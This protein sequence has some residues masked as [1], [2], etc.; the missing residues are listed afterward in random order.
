MLNKKLNIK[1]KNYVKNHFDKSFLKNK[2][3]NKNKFLNAPFEFVENRY[4]R[5]LSNKVVLDCGCGDGNRSVIFSKYSKK[6]IGIDFSKK[7]IEIAKK[8]NQR[9]NCFFNY[10]DI[11]NIKYKSKTFDYIFC[12]KTLL[13]LNLDVAFKELS[14][15]LKKNGKIIIIENLSNN[16]L[17]K[18]YRYF[19]NIIQFN[20][21]ARE[22]NTLN[23][24]ELKIINKYFF[25]SEK[26]FFDFFSLLGYLLGGYINL[27]NSKKIINILNWIDNFLLNNLKYT[28]LAFTIVMI[29]QKKKKF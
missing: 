11:H 8:K 15:V 12:Y 2:K 25:I 24:N 5:H 1:Y 18:Y 21:F 17:F 28:K 6:V 10:M 19:K 20:K 3:K 13:Y 22:F 16:L 26:F 9:S 23:D 29:L 27:I 14:R 4:L 7:S